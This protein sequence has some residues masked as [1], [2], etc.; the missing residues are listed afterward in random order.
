MVKIQM[1][2]RHILDLLLYACL[3][4]LGLSC[5]AQSRL[6][7]E[8]SLAL[9]S[10]GVPET[11]LSALV[12]PAGGGAARLAHFE[13]RPMSPASTMK[14]VTTLVALEELGP[15]Y[16]WK[17]HL[18]FSGTQERETLRGT[19][20][21]QGGGDPNL[22]WDAMREIFRSL[23]AQG[24]RHIRGDLVLDRSYFKPARPDVGSPQF[25][26]TPDAYYNVI[27]DALLLN[28]NMLKF[29]LESDAK[30]TRITV[31]PHLSGLRVASRQ[32]LDDTLCKDWD[33]DLL[34]ATLKARPWGSTLLTLEGPYPRDCK[35]TTGLNLMDRNAYIDQFVRTF[36]NEVGGTWRGR[37]VD[38]ITATDARVLAT[39]S[40]ETLSSIVK[41]INKPSDNAMTRSLFMTL[42]EN[43]KNDPRFEQSTENAIAVVNDWFTRKGIAVQGLVVDNG[44]GLSRT[45]R[46]T[47]TQLAELLQVG[48]KSNWYPEFA[49]SMPIVGVDGTMRRRLKDSSMA[50]RIRIKTGTLRDTAAIAGYVRDRYDKDWV[51][52]A[53]IND[54]ASKLGRPALDALIE[55][56]A[57]GP[58]QVMKSAGQ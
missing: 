47:A 15:T 16:R 52:V 32:T 6:P 10:G 8:V 56:V 9:Q 36:W 20:Y 35:S 19:L 49:S 30:Q 22:T 41:L 40:S 17:T 13:T 27:P 31:S 5:H 21:L 29:K 25:D 42:G 7:D 3:I 44:S 33:D 46:I 12:L 11:S 53:F 58:E 14:L 37:I 4:G 57:K 54:N 55:W 50:G 43:R 28:G 2:H 26:E 34:T 23:R 38:G 45:E 48:L 1:P 39:R 24:V 51:V 18:L